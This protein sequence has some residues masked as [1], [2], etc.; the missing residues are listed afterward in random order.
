MYVEPSSNIRLL[1]GVPLDNRYLHTILFENDSLQKNYFISKQKYNLTNY[2]YQRASLNTIRVNI[3]VDKLYDCNYL[4]FRNNSYGF[5][6]FYAFISDIM[7]VNENTSQITYELD[8]MQT[9]LFNVEVK[10][11]FVEREHS[12]TDNIGD[13]II[14]ESVTTGEYV[15]DG[16]APLVNMNDSC[17][18]VA[19]TDVTSGTVSGELYDGV[20]SA[21]DLFAF[22]STD[23]DSINSKVSEYTTSPDSIVSMYMCPKILIGDIESG[24]R[25]LN[26]GTSAI[27]TTYLGE[28]L[29]GSESFGTYKPKNKKL[30]TYPF[31]YFNVDNA[32]G[33]SLP[34][35]YEFFEELTPT[36][37]ISGS[38]TQPVKVVARPSNYK[39][40]KYNEVSGYKTLNTENVTLEDYPMC[41]WNMESYNSWLAQ[42]CVPLA[43]NTI[44][45]VA[46]L[47]SEVATANNISN[48][49]VSSI[50]AVSRLLSTLYTASISS[51]LTR[52]TVANGN[53]NVAMN[54]QQFYM[55][56][57]HV[58]E[59]F[60]KV[61]DDFFSVYGYATNRVKVPNRNSRPHWN[62][63]KT[64]G[65]LCVGN[66]PIGHIKKICDIY[67]SG[68]TFWKS[69][70]EIGN[71]SLDNSV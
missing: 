47:S 12:E 59:Q 1:S 41:S 18:I 22:L 3:E 26:Y 20:Y 68:V 21:C 8:I 53:V 39:G 45:S 37:R 52:G 65:C 57:I 55:S 24:G 35:R 19:I 51:D 67:D 7:Y 58:S 13:N 61:I 23:V 49:A 15:Y 10:E 60:A 17:V 32:S 71:Y 25:K 66:V 46:G 64:V 33:S 30:Y 14:P 42:N 56:R 31:N 2:S 28:K 34:L 29:S 48:T 9:W 40:V 70:D 16:Y 69:G 44:S 43:L 38:I 6:W 36:I 5:K 54:T 27:S 11:C 63:V 4:M 62:Y 50:G